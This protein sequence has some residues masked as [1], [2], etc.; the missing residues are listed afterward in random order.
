MDTN[1]N[2]DEEYSILDTKL[3]APLR[4]VNTEEVLEQASKQG[5]FRKFKINVE[6][7][8]AFDERITEEKLALNNGVSFKNLGRDAILSLLDIDWN[9]ANPC[10]PQDPN[11]RLIDDGKIQVIYRDETVIFLKNDESDC[12]DKLI[13]EELGKNDTNWRST[14]KSLFC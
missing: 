14:K 13:L 10:E 12:Y 8:I 7:S 5:L 9:D 6:F 11:K 1:K 2:K 3:N 4:I